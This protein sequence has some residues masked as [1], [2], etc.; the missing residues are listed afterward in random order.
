VRALGAA[1][2]GDTGESTTELFIEIP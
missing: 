1:A 2:S